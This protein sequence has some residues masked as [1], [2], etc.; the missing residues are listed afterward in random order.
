MAGGNQ[1][2]VHRLRHMAAERRHGFF[3]QHPEQAGLCRQRQFANFIQKQNTAMG[4]TNIPGAALFA[5]TGKGTADITEQFGFQQ[6]GGQGTAVHRHQRAVGPL[7]GPVQAAHQMILAGTGF[8]LYQQRYLAGH[9]LE[10][11]H[12]MG[13]SRRYLRRGFDG[14]DRRASGLAAEQR[15]AL[16]QR[17]Q[18]ALFQLA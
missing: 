1:L 11:G 8:A 13:N 14:G 3:L 2:K 7:A 17:R 18:L 16:T 15:H 12:F 4:G 10:C 5:A 9:Q 6:V